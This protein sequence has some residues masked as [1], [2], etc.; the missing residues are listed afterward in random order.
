MT[1]L[2]CICCLGPIDN[3]H[4]VSICHVASKP[5]NDIKTVGNRDA[6]TIRIID[7]D[8]DIMHDHYENELFLEYS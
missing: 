1:S 5:C 2:S 4:G 3:G 6:V 7:V 8:H